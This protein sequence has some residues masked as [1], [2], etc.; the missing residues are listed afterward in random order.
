MASFLFGAKIEE[1]FLSTYICHP[2][3][4]NNELSGPTV[5]TFIAKWMQ[6]LLSEDT[7]TGL[8]L[9][10]NYGSISYLARTSSFTKTCC[11]RI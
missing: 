6:E 1:I 9:Y 10:R 7:L 8:F 3:M 4:A 5:L 11:G 2:S